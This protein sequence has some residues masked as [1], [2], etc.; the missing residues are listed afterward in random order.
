MLFD[1]RAQVNE[2]DTKFDR[3][4]QN[5]MRMRVVDHP[6]GFRWN[7]SPLLVGGYRYFF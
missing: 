3:I 4:R 6:T 7:D 2:I 5:R 1:I